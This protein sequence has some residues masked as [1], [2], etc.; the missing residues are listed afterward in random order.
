MIE[1]CFLSGGLA[2]AATT[3]A[4]TES[5]GVG[6]GLLPVA[7]R[8]PAIAPMEIAH[9]VASTRVDSRRRSAMEWRNG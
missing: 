8:N 6:V 7:V 5:I 3:L 9:S 1:D 4:V 2:M